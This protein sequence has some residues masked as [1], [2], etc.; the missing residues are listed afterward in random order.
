MKS[1]IPKGEMLFWRPDAQV[2]A[3]RKLPDWAEFHRVC[4]RSSLA[5]DHIERSGRVYRCNAFEAQKNGGNWSFIDRGIGEGRTVV[6][7]L[8]AAY[9]A[10]GI[11]V[12][13]AEVLLVR[14]L[15]GKP[16]AVED[17][18]EALLGDDFEGLL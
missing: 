1:Y 16:V 15:S 5:F 11:D 12:P 10:S 9:R 7:A 2:E 3:A 17:D 14:G 13:G 8:A 6:D 18:F 4:G